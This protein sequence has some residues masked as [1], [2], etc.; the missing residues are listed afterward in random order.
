LPYTWNGNIYNAA[1][2]YKDTLTSTAGCDS[3][4]T[5]TLTVNSA[6]TGAET[7]TICN[8]QLPY[9]W[10]GNIYNA[11][12]TYKD[13]LTSTAGCDSIVTLTLAVTTAVTGSETAN[14]CANQLPY[15]WNG[16]IYNAAG[17]Y[18]DTLISTAGCDS[19]VTLTLTV[20]PVITGTQ[21]VTICPNQLPYLWNGNSYNTTGTYKD[22]LISV[23]GCD[24][25]VTLFLN[26][27][28][29]SSKTEN[30]STC[31]TS[32][33][34]PNGVM[35]NT[36]G[37][38][39]SNFTNQ[40]GCDSIIV[41]NL[42]FQPS[43]NL[44]VNNPVSDCNQTTI[45]LTAQAI[46]AGSDAGLNFTYWK[47]SA[48]SRPQ[49]TPNAINTSGTYYIK[50]TTA[51]GCYSIKPVT[52]QLN[53]M[54][55]AT[56][57]GGDICPGSKAKLTVTLSGK[58]PFNIT[59]T[60]GTVSHTVNA[61]TS[62]Q[63]QIE[64]SPTTNTIYTISSISD[65]LCTNNSL[66]ASAAVNIIQAPAGIR[67]TEVVTGVNVATPLRARGLG[68]NYAYKW[69]PAIGLSKPDVLNPVFNYSQ[70]MDY[71]IYI[72]SDLGCIV[73]DT[74]AVKVIA[75]ANVNEPPNLWVPTA[76]SPHNK[77]GHNDFLYPFHVNIVQLR[78]FRVFNRW[79]ELVFETKTLDHGWDGIYKGVPQVM[80]TYTWT[81][82]A[83]G[84]DG[85]IFK[86]AGNAMLLR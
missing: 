51:A 52:A 29:A 10:N 14:I 5:L 45:D 28:T 58:A 63:Y 11:A 44:V 49:S 55:T 7:I 38:Y 76:W 74:Q 6:V 82:E 70:R 57:S 71:L 81:V 22:T 84:N 42:S 24:S 53:R 12:G 26:V 2:T 30:I 21:S 48:A 59:Y 54:P 62:S 4:I 40:A 80:D 61:I 47:D 19:I 3:I 27:T 46:T 65:A 20:K 86:K 31:A 60:D 37:V 77:D 9:T 64:V 17:T 15:L 41:T 67:Y 1:G 32:Y 66:D 69:T 73:I 13:T 35:V 36:S 8:N 68:G 72:T 25:I 23:S 50:A 43:P 75:R 39:T 79:G 78:Y 16:N 85:T 34:L 83:V 33:K 18:K 56:I